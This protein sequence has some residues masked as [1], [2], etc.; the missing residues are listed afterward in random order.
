MLHA[1]VLPA[2]IPLVYGYVVRCAAL[3]VQHCVLLLA[4]L[5]LQLAEP[6]FTLCCS[7]LGPVVP[8][9]ATRL[10]LFPATWLLH[11][12]MAAVALGSVALRGQQR[13]VT[14][15]NTGAREEAPVTRADDG[16]SISVTAQWVC[17]ARALAF[18]LH[19]RGGDPLAPQLLHLLP[20][21]SVGLLHCHIAKFRRR[22]SGRAAVPHWLRREL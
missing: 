10:L 7:L 12:A 13:V 20:A 6:L 14:R 5:Y 1:P 19:M 17:F 8:D 2:L 15:T 16:L 22:L 4:R 18:T 11:V 3:L 21:G 9:K